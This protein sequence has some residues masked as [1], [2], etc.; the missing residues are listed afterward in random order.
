[1]TPAVALL[2]AAAACLAW[3]G[4]RSRPRE[5]L[6]ALETRPAGTA[7]TQVPWGRAL[8]A[9]ATTVWRHRAIRAATA[10]ALLAWIGSKLLGPVGF[11]GGGLVGWG[12]VPLRGRRAERR[13]D[14]AL[15]RQLGELSDTMAL[16]LRSGLSVPL[17]LEFGASEAEEPMAE[18]LAAFVDERRLGA[19]FDRALGNLAESLGSEDARLFTLVVGLHARSGGD[20]AAA[21]GDVTESIRHR[22]AV[23]T[24]LRALSTQGRV[25]GAIMGSLP[26][27]FLAVLATTSRRQL[28]P[29]YR[30]GP[31]IAM[32]AIGLTMEALAYL[33]I[34]HLLKVEG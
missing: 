32:L 14:E 6:V 27:A 1:V 20:L 8:G 22:V 30:S 25:S 21:L 9:I 19:T 18:L 4:V 10:G 28:G 12:V 13:R 29:V 34:R 17:A 11:L 16:A 24:E 2:A 23:R 15:E 3:W 7:T 31:G 33:W 26:I 5:G